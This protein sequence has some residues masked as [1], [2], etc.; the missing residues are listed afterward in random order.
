MQLDLDRPW[1]VAAW[2][3][4]S[5]QDGEVRPGSDVD[6]AVL[7]EPRPSWTELAELQSDLSLSCG[8][9]V[10]LVVLN[11]TSSVLRMEALRGKPIFCRD[12]E[13]RAVFASRAAMEY[14]EDMALAE[15]G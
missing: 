6:V 5:A 4:G 11:G 3:F 10:D 7:A 9:E 15:R 14:E 8:H 13:R 1:V 2:L 12:P